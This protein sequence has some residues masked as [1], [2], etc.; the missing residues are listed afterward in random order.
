[1]EIDFPTRQRMFGERRVARFDKFANQIILRFQRL[2]FSDADVINP[3]VAMLTQQIVVPVRADR[4]HRQV[5]RKMQI[6][7]DLRSG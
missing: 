7:I 3:R 5:E 4:F 1:M 6:M 2:F